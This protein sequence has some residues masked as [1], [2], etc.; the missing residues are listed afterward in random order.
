MTSFLG[1]SAWFFFLVNVVKLPFSVGLGVIRPETLWID[2]VLAPVVL[3]SAYGGRL[4]AARMDPVLFG[5][6]V[7]VLTVLSS[8]YLV[9][10]AF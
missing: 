9:V 8:L 4:L 6:I 10:S 1:T 5:R 7:T 2:L 3:A